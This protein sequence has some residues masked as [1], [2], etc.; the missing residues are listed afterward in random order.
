MKKLS[1]LLLFVSALVFTGCDNDDNNTTYVIDLPTLEAETEYCGD[2]D[3]P[4]D[5][6][7]Y[8]ENGP[9][10]TKYYHTIIEDK[11][12]IF[13][14]DCVSTS[15]GVSEGFSLTN[16]KNNASGYEAVTKKG[17]NGST[18]ILSFYTSPEYANYPNAAIHFKNVTDKSVSKEYNLKGLYLTNSSAAVSDMENGNT[19]T[20]ASAF[21]E[22]DWYKITIYNMDKTRSVECFLADFRNGKSEIV[23]EWKWFDLS[24]L[25]S[26]KGIKFEF[27]SSDKNQ[28]GVLTA[29]YFCIDGI[30]IEEI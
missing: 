24:S 23:K 9:N 15:W 19:W 28:W 20:T 2:L 5:S 17:V 27:D 26:T 1:L 8:D 3:N 16:R 11:T 4:I 14:F 12:G 22:G 21:E 18:Y 29:S 25:G 7:I 10:E 13:S 30:T 6:W